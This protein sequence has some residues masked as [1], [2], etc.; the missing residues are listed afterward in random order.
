MAKNKKKLVTDL[1][2]AR[3][4]KRKDLKNK[5]RRMAV[6]FGAA[7]LVVFIVIQIINPQ[8]TYYSVKSQIGTLI[9]SPK[10]PVESGLGENIQMKEIND[11]P[12]ILTDTSF[13]VINNKGYIQNSGVHNFS[14]PILEVSDDK[15][16]IYENGGN[17]FIRGSQ[18]ESNDPLKTESKILSANIANN[19]NYVIVTESAKYLNEVIVYDE[20][21]E[22]LYRWFSASE[23]VSKAKFNQDG[24]KLFVNSMVAKNG[25]ITTVQYMLN[26]EKVDPEHRVEV[27]DFI[28]IDFE[29]FND[30]IRMIGDRDIIDV[31]FNGEII[32]KMSFENKKL[33]K[34]EFSGKNIVVALAND[35]NSFYSQIKVLDIK[36]KEVTAFDYNNNID[37]I[38]FDNKQVVCLTDDN[39]TIYNLKG[40]KTD[41]KIFDNK[42]GKIQIIG[43]NIVGINK[44]HVDKIDN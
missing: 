31:N 2:V 20:K 11:K 4:K 26:I 22:E 32:N 42:V 9:S 19:G 28:A 23:Y 33:E 29:Y 15:F 30:F 34:Y 38:A 39:L 8:K 3:A 44:N 24:N 27:N 5:K 1:D 14:D 35:S 12:I 36:L 40:E 10:F 13:Y 17:E 25:S 6:A 41:E 43:N 37:D 18:Y 16:I 7:L 21:H